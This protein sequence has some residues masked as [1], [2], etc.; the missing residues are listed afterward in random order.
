MKLDDFLAIDADKMSMPGMIG[1]VGVVE[2]SGLTEAD[3][4]EETSAD[5]KR[6]GAIDRGAGNLAIFAAGL[7][8]K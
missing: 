5:K 6:E 4:A 8:E 2:G 3:L 1:K 7:G